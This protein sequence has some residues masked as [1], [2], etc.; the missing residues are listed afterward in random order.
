MV[1]S[2]IPHERAQ[3]VAADRGGKGGPRTQEDVTA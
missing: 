2:S 1:T 3:R